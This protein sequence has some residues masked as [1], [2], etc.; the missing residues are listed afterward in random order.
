MEFYT[1]QQLQ[2]SAQALRARLNG[3]F[4]DEML[5]DDLK[6]VIKP[7]V[8]LTGTGGKNPVMGQT[9]D[10]LFVLSEQEIF[11]RKV[12]SMVRQIGDG[13]V[14]RMAATLPPSVMSAATAT[15]TVT[16][17][18]T[19][20]AWPSASAFNPISRIIP[21]RK[22]RWEVLMKYPIVM[23]LKDGR[24]ETL[25]T[26]QDFEYLIDEFMGF[27]ALQYFRALREEAAD[28][29]RELAEGTQ[30]TKNLVSELKAKIL[31]LECDFHDK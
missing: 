30:R 27:E 22:G 26:V 8:K 3:S 12:F 20:M 31:E 16:A 4:F 9:V 6:A 15:P 10:K 13:S 18:T 1:Y 7:C 21:P 23:T 14:L 11:G 19:V 17:P 5:P 28:R 25:F 29:E 2:E 24:N